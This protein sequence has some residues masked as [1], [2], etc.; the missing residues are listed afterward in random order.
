MK[1]ILSVLLSMV[2]VLMP[3]TLAVSAENFV[4]S[5]GYK[6]APDVNDD[7]NGCI[8]ITSVEEAKTTVKIPREVAD[9]LIAKYEE[10]SANG[11]KLSSL[12]EGLNDLVAE[13]LGSEYDA[14]IL[15]IRDFFNIFSICDDMNKYLEVEGQTIELQFDIDLNGKLPYVLVYTEEDGWEIITAE[16]NGDGTVSMVFEDFGHVAVLVPMDGYD[17]SQGGET[18]SDESD[19]SIENSSDESDVSD[20]TSSEAS[21]NSSDDT[22]QTGDSSDKT[23]WFFVM[24]AALAA[25]VAL[26]V[27]NRNVF[28]TKKK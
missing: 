19:V 14:D 7:K 12:D 2:M 13:Q 15:V 9:D 11:F 6:P 8:I 5:I 21:D 1:K 18:S 4:P 20:E 24:F 25:I 3:L 16:D 27:I 23:I 17:N 22:P 10:L 28:A 26:S